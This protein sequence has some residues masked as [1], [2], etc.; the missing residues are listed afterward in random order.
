[1]FNFRG[2]AVILLIHIIK[3]LN[4]SLQRSI[5]L[6]RFLEAAP[7]RHLLH[8]SLLN[9]SQCESATFA[10]LMTANVLDGSHCVCF[11]QMLYIPVSAGGE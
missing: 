5:R 2:V 8:L 10:M 9:E 11:P 6:I 1:M 4:S 7:Q 3:Q